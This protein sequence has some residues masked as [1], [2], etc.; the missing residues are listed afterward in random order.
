M[1]HIHVDAIRPVI[2]GTNRWKSGPTK[3]VYRSPGT[4]QL[5]LVCCMST[6][7]GWLRVN[8]LQSGQRGCCFNRHIPGGGVRLKGQ[9]R[10]ANSHNKIPSQSPT[11][12]RDNTEAHS[13]LEGNGSH[14]LAHTGLQL[15][16]ISDVNIISSASQHV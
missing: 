6:H 9:R 13:E 11:E 12:N 2:F 15:L 8:V 1:R 7:K 10:E 14:H 16:M 3:Q 4:A 5:F